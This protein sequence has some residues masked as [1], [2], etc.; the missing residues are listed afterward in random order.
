MV[1]GTVSGV[2][3]ASTVAIA[4]AS[5]VSAAAAVASSLASLSRVA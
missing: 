2:E 5:V 1:G 4:A 3:A